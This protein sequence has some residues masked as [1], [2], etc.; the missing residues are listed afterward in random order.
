MLFFGWHKVAPN[1]VPNRQVSTKDISGPCSPNWPEL[2]PQGVNEKLE[3]LGFVSTT[4]SAPEEDRGG[5]L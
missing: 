1:E 4:S 5:C 2:K 3:A